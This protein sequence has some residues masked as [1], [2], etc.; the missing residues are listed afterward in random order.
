MDGHLLSPLAF[1]GTLLLF[2]FL[3][4]AR[5]RSCKPLAI[6]RES[7]ELTKCVRLY[8]LPSEYR[9]SMVI[10]VK[11]K[12]S[13]ISYLMVLIFSPLVA[14][15]VY[16]STMGSISNP[17]LVSTDSDT[18]APS[19]TQ[20]LL[21]SL[22]HTLE[23]GETLG[24]R[25]SDLGFS[26]QSI[27][28]I[29]QASRLDLD[30]SLDLITPGTQFGILHQKNGSEPTGL[31][32]R[33]SPYQVIRYILD[34]EGRVAMSKEDLPVTMEIVQ[35]RGEVTSNLWQ[36]AQENGLPAQHIQALAEIFAWQMDFN[37]EIQVGDQWRLAIE[38]K[39]IEG[40]F[41]AWGRIIAAEY[42]KS[43]PEA[44]P[45]TA[46]Y[47]SSE[48]GNRSGYFDHNGQSLQKMFL[49]S[50]L[51][52]GRVTSRF[53][54]RRFHPIAKV[55]RPHRGVDYGAPTGTPVHSVA[56]GVIEKI[57]HFG[58][59]GRMIVIRHGQGY[60][61]K[62][63]HLNRFQSGLR[64]G[65]RIAQGQVIGTVGQ[66]GMAT[67]PHLH[68][69]FLKGGRFYD[70]LSFEFPSANPIPQDL[71]A[72]FVEARNRALIHLPAYQ[73]SVSDID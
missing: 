8:S 65:S 29:S 37:R 24:G 57:G 20:S 25:L 43:Q 3:P 39:F 47:F 60:Q 59:A 26:A 1:I 31:V 50:P 5:Q 68:F 48:E 69:E 62:Y 38:K 17:T 34:A 16:F 23:K 73:I 12:V 52:F 36:S 32:L 33:R 40:E 7:F 41:V 4:M 13:F 55:H 72:A 21:E 56:D 58:G 11:V 19:P 67:G 49:K 2:L 22:K 51:K 53:S 18:R 28:L 66:T 10:Q 46:I 70:P 9:T 63:L 44:K 61:T 35:Y 30:T 71:M 64:N 15:I 45:L 54:R 42:L 27:H 14:T 6:S